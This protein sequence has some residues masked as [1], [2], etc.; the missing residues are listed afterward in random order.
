MD[1]ARTRRST[2]RV[3]VIVP[4]RDRRDLLGTLLSALE[5]QTFRDFEVVVVDDGSRDGSGDYAEAHTVADRPVTVVRGPGQGAVVARQAGVEAAA[6][7][8]LAFTDSDCVPEPGWLAAAVAAIDDGA[9]VVNGRTQPARPLRPLER[10]MGSSDEGLYPTCN[11][12]YRRAVFEGAGGFDGSAAA[13]LGFRMNERAQ[14]LGFGED[15]LLAWRVRRSGVETRYV[16]DA[17]VHHHV[18]PADFTDWL[19]RCWMAAAFPALVAEVP[20]LRRN[21]V[22]RGVLFGTRTRVPMY[23]TAVALLMRNRAAV[24]LATAWWAWTRLRELRTTETPLAEQ[25]VALPKEMVLDVVTGAALVTG[26]VRAR[27]PLL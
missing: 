27:T 8:V 25:L 23:A 7:G 2:A 24:G 12:L 10:S 11:V 5:A 19:S 21:L 22:R 20:E 1:E 9:G 15:T 13:R 6:G 17:V 16:P 4:V 3:S 26:S 14:G 18:F